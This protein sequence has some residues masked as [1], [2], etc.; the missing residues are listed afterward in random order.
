MIPKNR[1]PTT[2]GEVLDK[3]FLEPLGMT[4]A[5][6][7]AEMGVSVQTV[8]LLINGKRDVTAETALLLSRVFETSPELWMNLQA[9]HDLWI[10]RRTLR[11]AG[12]L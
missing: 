11:M 2:P 1:E 8:N 12:R 3:E 4:Q 9:T 5:K 10:A 7:A 6:L